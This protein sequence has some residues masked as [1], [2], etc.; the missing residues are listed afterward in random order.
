MQTNSLRLLNEFS[1]LVGKVLR[2][3]LSDRRQFARCEKEMPA[4][5]L[6]WQI[7]AGPE[8]NPDKYFIR[9]QRLEVSWKARKRS[10]G[11]PFRAS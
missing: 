6:L 2:E 5:N 1:C 8:A 3:P 11:E 9:S 10:S 4:G 7:V